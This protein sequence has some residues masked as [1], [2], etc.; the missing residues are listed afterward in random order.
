[1]I[2]PIPDTKLI[3]NRNFHHLVMDIFWFGLAI[4][5]TSRFLAMY[6]LRVGSTPVQIGWLAAFPAL[7]LFIA[8]TLSSWWIQRY[9]DS[10]HA[11]S[12][13]ALGFR[14]AY[15][16]PAFTPFLPK[17]WQPIWLIVSVSL[18]ALPQGI[19]SVIF[20]VMMRRA[21]AYAFLMEKWALL[22]P[23]DLMGLCIR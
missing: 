13:P 4:P 1:M 15:L 9:P 2:T 18:P 19:A 23:L 11:I 17:Q 10:V 3:E 20:L 7:I 8:A 16:L 22:N 21:I 12:W 6:A 5:A 14:L